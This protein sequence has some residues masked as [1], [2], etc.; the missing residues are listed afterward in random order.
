MDQLSVKLFGYEEER[1]TIRLAIE[2]NKSLDVVCLHG[3][4]G[5]GKTTI[6]RAVYEKYR[7]QPKYA[8]TELLDFD[9]LRL[10]I[11]QTLL[12]HESVS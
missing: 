11:K 6:L 7:K 12:V 3:P 4:G 5:I 1:E 8:V 10:H 2:K 9:N